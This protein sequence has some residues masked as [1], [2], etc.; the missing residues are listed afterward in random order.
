VLCSWCGT[1]L[2]D[3][4]QFCLKCGQKARAAASEAPS[5]TIATPACSTCGASLSPAASSCRKCGQPVVPT[6][7]SAALANTV[8]E[9]LAL[10]R[11]RRRNR[12]LRWLLVPVILAA[13]LWVATSQSPSA[14]EVQEYM[15]WS[16]AQTIVDTQAPLN[17]RSFWSHEFTVPPGALDVSLSGEF[18]ALDVNPQHA[19]GRNSESGKDHNDGIEAYVLTNSAFA[20]W[21]G[22]YSTDTLY[23]SGSLAGDVIN[24]PLP[25]GAGVYELVFSNRS[26][27]NAKTVHA[28]VLL[29]YKSGWPNAALR[30][31]ERLWN[32]MGL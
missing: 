26:S 32:W 8:A 9:T 15:H 1:N 12:I 3:G 24:A 14:Q 30:L 18:T 23:Q 22:G 19:N 4:S 7:N 27:P 10:L 13:L 31:K 25:A 29:R 17:P 6:A 21:S 16:Q 11:A 2:P 5:E 20:V 28:T